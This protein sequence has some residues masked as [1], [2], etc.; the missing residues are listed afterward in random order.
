[1]NTKVWPQLLKSILGVFSLIL[2]HLSHQSLLLESQA[3]PA[4]PPF[5]KGVTASAYF[6]PSLML[7]MFVIIVLSSMS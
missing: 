4:S 2:P 6:R 3:K 5:G 7:F 1:M